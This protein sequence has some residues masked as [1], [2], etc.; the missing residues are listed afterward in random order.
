MKALIALVF[1]GLT[2]LGAWL[3]SSQGAMVWLQDAIRYCF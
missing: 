2:G 3:W 1:V